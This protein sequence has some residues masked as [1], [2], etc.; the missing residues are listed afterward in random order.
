MS[1]VAFVGLGNMGGPMAAH[2]ITAGHAVIGFD[3]SQESMARAALHGVA[4]SA[5]LREAVAG[6]EVVITML[7]HGS[8]VED[9][10]TGPDGVFAH[11]P[12]PRLVIDSSTIDAA[13]SRRLHLAAE[14]AGHTFLD[15]PVSGGMTGAENATLTFMVGGDAAR[16][17]E[18]RPLLEAMGSRVVHA[19][20]AGAGS[21]AKIAN[22]MLLGISLAGVCE[23]FVLAERMGLD[24][25]T[26][27]DIATTSSGDCWALRT[28]TPVAGI[29]DSAPSS[30]DWA[31]GFSSQLMLKDLRLAAEAASEEN[32]HL[33]IADRVLTM[34]EQHV[35]NGKGDLDCSSLIDLVQEVR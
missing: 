14:E 29:V 16:V 15:A 11:L 28:W 20:P 18:A 25:S 3:Q 21:A 23:A 33:E 30:N 6:A 13:T 19:G 1:K 10:L 34:Y 35:E 9:V 2:L 4:T 32:V 24:A 12:S 17:Q 27:F 7:P 26:F 8:A 31:P 5:S 22:N